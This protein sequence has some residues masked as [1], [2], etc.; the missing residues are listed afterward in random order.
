MFGDNVAGSVDLKE[1]FRSYQAEM[2][3]T[4][5][6]SR[7]IGHAPTK[8]D[9]TEACWIRWF[10][11]YLPKRYQADKGFVVDSRGSISEQIDVIVYDQHYS[12]FLLN[13]GNYVYVPAE[14]V[15]AVFEIKQTM[16]S[17]FL[18]YSGNKVASVRGLDRTSA[19][20][21][22]AAGKYGPRELFNILGGILS[23][24]VEWSPP[25]G[26]TFKEALIKMEDVQR[27]DIG[28]SILK[29]AFEI[30]Y[31]TEKQEIMSETSDALL[32]FFLR[33]LSRL[34]E[35]GTVPAIQLDAYLDLVRKR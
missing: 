8:G 33:F 7:T 26:D 14:S 35:L 24:D 15:Y 32:F 19:P 20:I 29:G 28:C 17:G 9:E 13:R 2:E 21:T 5:C 1:L 30:C 4:L 27:L 11:D 25:F 10:K 34:Q 6:V 12:P 23:Y 18:E 3:K 31:K 22:Y 16:N